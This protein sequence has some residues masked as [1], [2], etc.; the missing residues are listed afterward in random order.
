MAEQS[1]SIGLTR[2]GQDR[3]A[4]LTAAAGFALAAPGVRA[5]EAG[6]AAPDVALPECALGAR[7]SDLR[8]LWVYLDFWASW[9]GP[10]RQSFPWMAQLQRQYAARGLRVVA[11]NLDA[12]R[13]DADAFLARHPAGF[14]L[15]YDPSGESARRF[16]VRGMPSSALIDPH[17]RLR[18]MHRGFRSDDAA[19]LEARVAQA[20]TGPAS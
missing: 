8:G 19:A 6:E 11:V 18:W 20:L 10:C 17:G 3:R 16:A 2:A 7:L 15:A 14:A 9:C 4:W 12:Q 5:L 1:V 13:S